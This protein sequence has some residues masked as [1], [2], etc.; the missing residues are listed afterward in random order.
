MQLRG[1]QLAASVALF[2]AVGGGWDPAA[3]LPASVTTP[4]STS[5]SKP[6]PTRKASS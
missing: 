4:L 6:A 3:P 2:T 5:D 1:R